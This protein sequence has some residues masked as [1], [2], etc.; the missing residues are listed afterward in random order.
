[1]NGVTA[2]GQRG[3]TSAGAKK[4]PAPTIRTM[5]IPAEKSRKAAGNGGLSGVGAGESPKDE[6]PM[7]PP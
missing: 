3:L 1:M 7:D 2:Q 4:R 6:Y 5:M